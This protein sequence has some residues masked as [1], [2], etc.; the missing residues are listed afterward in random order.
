[1]IVVPT[2][3]SG[4]ED[5]IESTAIATI[6]SAL[7]QCGANAHLA[8]L[9]EELVLGT[10]VPD[11]ILVRRAIRLLGTVEVT[12]TGGSIR[13]EL[14]FR[15]FAGLAAQISVWMGIAIDQSL[16]HTGSRAGLIIL[17]RTGLIRQFTLGAH[18]IFIAS[19]QIVKI[20]VVWYYVAVLKGA[21]GA[22]RFVLMG[23]SFG[24]GI[25]VSVI[26][27]F[28]IHGYLLFRAVV[29]SVAGLW[30]GQEMVGHSI[31]GNRTAGRGRQGLYTFALILVEKRSVSRAAT[32]VTHKIDACNRSAAGIGISD[33]SVIGK[34][35]AD[36][37]IPGIHQFAGL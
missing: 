16:G 2:T 25:E 1:V 3:Q 8:G 19:L 26:W 35:S 32:V 18:V 4:T 36:V 30:I 29:V 23:A 6:V 7:H 22:S 5:N 24:G 31:A 34:H 21:G 9:I 17:I 33:H 13:N 10:L 27:T 15:G 12:T 14:V 28:A 37:L 20:H 11:G